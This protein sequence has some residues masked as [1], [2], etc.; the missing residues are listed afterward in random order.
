MQRIER[1]D[2]LDSKRL[3]DKQRGYLASLPEMVAPF[4]KLSNFQQRLKNRGLIR[5]VQL[6]PEGYAK[7]QVSKGVDPEQPSEIIQLAWAI[8]ALA[9]AIRGLKR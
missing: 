1:T 9:D 2:A 8:R 5:V 3:S 7:S 6:Y 4:A